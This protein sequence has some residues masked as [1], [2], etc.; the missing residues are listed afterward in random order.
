MNRSRPLRPHRT[1]F[2]SDRERWR[3]AQV[4]SID[5]ETAQ[6]RMQAEA[7]IVRDRFVDVALLPD[8]ARQ[9]IG[10]A[11]ACRVTGTCADDYVIVEI[12]GTHFGG[13]SHGPGTDQ[14]GSVARGDFHPG[15][16]PRSIT[17]ES[18]FYDW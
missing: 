15:V 1:T 14:A 11:L 7:H 18:N 16:I 2:D 6:L 4:I 13:R 9:A 12:L 8:G 3:G 10:D 5:G 17:G